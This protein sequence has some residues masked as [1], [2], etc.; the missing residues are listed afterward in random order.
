MG[1]KR[2]PM[3]PSPPLKF[4]TA[5]FPQ[6]GFKREVESD[7]RR[8]NGCRL[9]RP[10]SRILVSYGPFGQDGGDSEFDTPV[11]RPLARQPVMLSSQVIAYYGLIRTTPSHSTAYLLRLPSN[12]GKEW[13]PNLSCTSVF[14]HAIPSTP[15]YR[16]G[17]LDCCFPKPRWSSP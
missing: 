13:V 12:S 9:I 1:K 8:R 7:L 15:V 11:Q 6:Y 2:P 3:V 10:P 14:L 16:L 5:G 4:R 17:A